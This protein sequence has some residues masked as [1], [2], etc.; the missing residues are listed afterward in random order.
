LYVT[1]AFAVGLGLRAAA[2]FTARQAIELCIQP[3]RGE[4]LPRLDLLAPFP[5][6]PF[7][8]RL[9]DRLRAG[10]SLG[11]FGSLALLSRI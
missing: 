7:L 8:R 2:R 1:A 10:F 6:L 5:P 11:N 9:G 3:P 4:L